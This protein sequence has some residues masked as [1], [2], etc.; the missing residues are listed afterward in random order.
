M[1]E[2]IPKKHLNFDEPIKTNKVFDDSFKRIY[3]ERKPMPVSTETSLI[4]TNKNPAEALPKVGKKFISREEEVSPQPLSFSNTDY[5]KSEGR[6]GGN[7]EA[8][9]S[10][11]RAEVFRHH[12]EKRFYSKGFEGEQGRKASHEGPGRKISA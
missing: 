5:S 6:N 8:R 7:G 4:G 9:E 1:R 10:K 2:H 3:G 11:E 12:I